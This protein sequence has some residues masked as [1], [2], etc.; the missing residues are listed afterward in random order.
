MSDVVTY[1]VVQPFE[2]NKRGKLIAKEPLQAR[3]I[4]AALKRAE[5]VAQRG[6]AVAFS[7]TGDPSSGDFDDPV[8]FG[9]F[10][11]VPAELDGL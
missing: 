11:R 7:R 8:I 3:S 9:R 6:G 10:G 5:S 2:T 4:P 1:Y